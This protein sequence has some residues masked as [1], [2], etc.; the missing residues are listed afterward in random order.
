MLSETSQDLSKHEEETHSLKSFHESDETKTLKYGTDE[1]QD[2]SES[3]K[4]KQ[5]Q[6]EQFYGELERIMG[7]CFPKESKANE[8]K[9]FDTLKYPKT[10]ETPEKPQEAVISPLSSAVSSPQVHKSINKI[11]PNKANIENSAKHSEAMIAS[12]KTPG[13]E[14]I[15]PRDINSNN[16]E[17][18]S[19]RTPNSKMMSDEYLDLKS[20][21]EISKETLQASYEAGRREDAFNYQFYSNPVHSNSEKVKQLMNQSDLRDDNI[22]IYVDQ[23]DNET[24][25]RKYDEIS[26]S[27]AYNANESIGIHTARNS[28]LESNKKD[29]KEYTSSEKYTVTEESAEKSLD[30]VHKEKQS[31]EYLQNN[32]KQVKKNLENSLQENLENSMS[33]P[34]YKGFV[35]N[36][37]NTSQELTE[38]ALMKGREHTELQNLPPSGYNMVSPRPDQLKS[39]E[40]YDESKCVVLSNKKCKSIDDSDHAVSIIDDSE[41]I[42]KQN[43]QNKR[44]DYVT[45]EILSMMFFSDIHDNPIFPYRS[46]QV[47]FEAQK[48]YP[49]N[50][51]LGI[52]TSKS[53]VEGFLDDLICHIEEY[54]VND[55]IQNLERPI[56]V[57]PVSCLAQLQFYEE[58]DIYGPSQT[59]EDILSG[60]V[61]Y[62]LEQL[63]KNMYDGTKDDHLITNEEKNNKIHNTFIHDKM[64][65]DSFNA[66]LAQLSKRKEE[67]CP[68]IRD[69]KKLTAKKYNEQR[70]FRLLHKTKLQV[71]KCNKIFDKAGTRKV[72]PPSATNSN[73]NNMDDIFAPP[74]PAPTD[75]ER[76]QQIR[77]EKLSTLLSNEINDEDKNW[78]QYNDCA[79]QVKL[80]LAD[81]ILED[82]AG[83]IA[84][85]LP[86]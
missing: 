14:I 29:Y 71:M 61:F 44:V 76:N 70:L 23:W 77:E 3:A 57:D 1:R 12:E 48:K 28:P 56:T 73:Q 15:T 38:S 49:F 60:E 9:Q 11:S 65:F 30:E 21:R 27:D 51:P 36:N 43:D 34:D 83:E 31:F 78:L 85:L 80:D 13:D 19:Y 63:R 69:P 62:S 82:L 58:T 74:P 84:F 20:Q 47:I 16:Q 46:K 18:L 26:S 41:E 2:H 40:D 79:T 24:S 8:E 25:A 33:S 72:P 39:P 42:Y 53:G 45:D 4:S 10:E 32:F 35:L 86:K 66:A 64:L 55:V 67:Q 7:S 37:S 52:N 68:W 17:Q 75:E 59:S 50:K 5:S 54:Y 6:K 81:M 22:H